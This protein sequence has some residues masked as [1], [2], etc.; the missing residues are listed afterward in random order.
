M[1]A[2]LSGLA[3]RFAA[4]ED[5]AALSVTCDEA[6]IRAAA[7]ALDQMASAAG[8]LAAGQ[9][10]ANEAFLA[11]AGYIGD[12]AHSVTAAA[13]AGERLTG[14]ISRAALDNPFGGVFEAAETALLALDGV[15]TGASICGADMTSF[16]TM[17]GASICTVFS[18]TT[19]R[20]VS[21]ISGLGIAAG[22][23]AGSLPGYFS[24]PLNAIAAMFQALS[25]SAVSALNRIRT[26]ASS[27][28]ATVSA[29]AGSANS[30]LNSAYA[31][32]ASTTAGTAAVRRAFYDVSAVGT[33]GSAALTVFP[34]RTETAA[35]LLRLEQ[36]VTA[37]PEVNLTVPE[38]G[39]KAPAQPVIHIQVSNENHIGNEADVD[40]ILRAFEL[41]LTDA[42]AGCAERVF[43]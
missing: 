7:A 38:A 35:S 29:A 42:V 39:A 15:S 6:A 10:A 19:A 37:L 41:R 4:L 30:A 3:Q 36:E 28:I 13:D 21:E 5:N 14:C 12:L 25:A 8:G 26:A 43:L 40:A 17:A 32:D 33:S 23:T 18:D 27:T 22:V 16:F 1:A 34:A 2:S 11:G 9:S 20:S 24:G 31:S